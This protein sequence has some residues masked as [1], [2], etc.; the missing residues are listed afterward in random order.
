MEYIKNTPNKRTVGVIV[1]FRLDEESKKTLSDLGINIIPTIKIPK[2]QEAVCGHADMMIHN[3]KSNK[4]VVAAEVYEYFS[5]QLIGADLIKGSKMLDYNYPDD[6]LYN[7]ATVGDFV[8]CNA[9]CT[10]IEILSEYHSLNRRILSVKQGYSKCSIC[11]VNDNAIIT[12]DKSIEKICKENK[13]DVLSISPG[14]IEL[15]GMNYG[16]IGGA[17]GLINKNTLAV[18][19]ELNTHIDSDNIKAFCKNHRVDIIE[20]K[21]GIIT[22]VG[23]ILPISSI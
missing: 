5:K 1:D 11:I 13:I 12:S 19:G 7:C 16:F 23:S 22:D 3:I 15:K 8:I 18:N 10:A 21:K 6:I 17:T 20:L 4:F 9:A 14:Y 2:L